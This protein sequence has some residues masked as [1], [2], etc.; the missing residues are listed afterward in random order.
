MAL[1][2]KFGRP[3]TFGPITFNDLDKDFDGEAA[4]K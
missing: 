3:F 1:K 2:Q 4:R